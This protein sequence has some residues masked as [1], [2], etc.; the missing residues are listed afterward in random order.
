MKYPSGGIK[1]LE[2]RLTFLNF[3]G[4]IL[5]GIGIFELLN[6]RLVS[7]D[8][9]SSNGFLSWIAG[10]DV[11]AL[12]LSLIVIGLLFFIISKRGVEEQL[13]FPV[14][15]ITAAL[16]MYGNKALFVRF[17][18][19]GAFEFRMFAKTFNSATMEIANRI[20][21]AN[22]YFDKLKERVN[23]VERKISETNQ[24]TFNYQEL[25]N[26]FSG[27]LSNQQIFLNDLREI[28]NQTKSWREEYEISFGEMAEEMREITESLNLITI[29]IAIESA[30]LEQEQFQEISSNSREVFKNLEQLSIKFAESYSTIRSDI[31]FDV[32]QIIE[33]NQLN[34][35]A[36]RNIIQ[37]LDEIVNKL[38][39][40]VKD[41]IEVK[42]INEELREYISKIDQILPPSY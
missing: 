11:L 14:Q 7:P 17:I 28:Y 2:R 13:I 8:T 1:R 15:Q 16:D 34:Q 6:N 5:L 33:N 21:M 25:L 18:E 35:E 23:D 24:R 41:R 19:L 29:N 37:G 31:N 39:I 40:T 20:D 32:E 10:W 36:V 42:E 38:E 3:V 26:Q 4:G 9:I 30:N 27:F 12:S 22:Q